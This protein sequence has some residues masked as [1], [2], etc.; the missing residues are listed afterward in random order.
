[1]GGPKEF[2]NEIHIELEGSPADYDPKGSNEGPAIVELGERPPEEFARLVD[3]RVRVDGVLE[4]D[5]YRQVR[6]AKVDYAT[7][8]FGP[9]RLTQIGNIELAEN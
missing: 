9:P 1:M 6:E 2:R 8:I 3:K 4:L 7:V 5:P